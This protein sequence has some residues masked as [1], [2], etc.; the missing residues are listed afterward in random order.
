VIVAGYADRM[1]R[2]FASSPGFRWRVAHHSDFPDYTSEE[3][4]EIAKLMLAQQSYRSSEAGKQA[5][6]EYIQHRMR[7][8]HFANARPGARRQATRLS[9]SRSRTLSTE[10]LM[11]IEAGEIRA[12]HV[13]EGGIEPAR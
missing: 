5:F 7:Q 1:D 4:F 11:T 6:R 3:L 8:P 9:E 2:F 12:T 10:D 13:F